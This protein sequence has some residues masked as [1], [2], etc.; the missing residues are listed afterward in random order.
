MIPGYPLAPE[1]PDIA[2]F[3][4]SHFQQYDLKCLAQKKN[5]DKATSYFK[6]EYEWT[7]QM[8]CDKWKRD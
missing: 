5:Q 7:L 3:T 6:E 8:L 2:T 1:V 4:I